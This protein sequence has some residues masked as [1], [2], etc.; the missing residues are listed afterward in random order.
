MWCLPKDNEVEK[1][2]SEKYED[3]LE[4]QKKLEIENKLLREKVEK[5]ETKWSSNID[6]FVEQWYEDNR[7]EIDIGV[8]DLK[9]FKVD[10]MPDNLEK[11]IYKKVLK[12]VFSFLNSSLSPKLDMADEEE[13]MIQ[14]DEFIV[15]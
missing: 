15:A 10:L 6:A 7:D 14:R 1:R 2:L 5:A 3:L 13:I 9:F 4:R 8:V 12:I 11:H